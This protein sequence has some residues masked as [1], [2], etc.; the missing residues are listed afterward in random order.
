M[1][2]HLIFGDLEDAKPSGT[3]ATIVVA[4]LVGAGLMYFFSPQAPG[5]SEV[6]RDSAVL[7]AGADSIDVKPDAQLTAAKLQMDVT[8]SSGKW[9]FSGNLEQINLHITQLQSEVANA[10]DAKELAII[11]AE[12]DELVKLR[13]DI[14]A[15]LNALGYSD[16]SST[17][18][19]K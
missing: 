5:V 18:T 17:T 10:K 11:T 12:R 8:A 1:K 14:I 3:F 6:S 19:P 15:Q 16:T 7:V 4:L 9:L 2:N 13:L